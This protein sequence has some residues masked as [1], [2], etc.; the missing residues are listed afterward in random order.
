MGGI[1][2]GRA[3]TE[4]MMEQE[5]REGEKEQRKANRKRWAME[6]RGWPIGDPGGP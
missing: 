4:G 2:E 1:I 5:K 3:K 6:V